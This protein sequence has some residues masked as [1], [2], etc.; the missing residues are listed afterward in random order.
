MDPATG[1]PSAFDAQGNPL[2]TP[3]ITPQGPTTAQ[4]PLFDEGKKQLTQDQELATQKLT[5]IKNAQMALKL[6]P[7]VASGPG[8]GPY[9]Q[10]VAFLKAQGIVPTNPNDPTVVYQE[11]NK[12]LNRY[13]QQSGLSQRSDAA[14][15]LAENSNPNLMTQLNPALV[16]LT[17]NAIALDRVEASRPTAFKDKDLS[18]YGAFRSTYPQQIDERAFKMDLMP[19][20]EASKLFNTMLQKAKKGDADAIKFIKSLDIANKQGF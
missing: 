19:K 7:G 8:T 9:N 11:I 12:Y 14:Q 10:A 3:G 18:K 5:G 15:A 4:P 20:P 16:N 2:P 1:K 6:L 13:V 17:A